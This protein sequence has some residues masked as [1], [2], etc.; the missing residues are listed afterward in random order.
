MKTII[1]I[2]SHNG[3]TKSP[4]YRYTLNPLYEVFHIEPNPNLHEDLEKLNSTLVKAGI[5]DEN[6]TGKLYFDKRGFFSRKKGC[7]IEKKKGMRSSFLKENNYINSFLTDEYVEVKIMTLD[8]LVDYL[9][10]TNIYLLK[11]DTEGFD[12]RILNA[13]SWSVKPHKIITEDFSETNEE[14]YELLRSVGY[15]LLKNDSSDSVWVKTN[16]AEE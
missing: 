6:G 9:G 3:K 4:T 11:V 7:S 1:D 12:F 14:K 16:S 8:K 5:S 15:K 2:G 10:L 13:Y